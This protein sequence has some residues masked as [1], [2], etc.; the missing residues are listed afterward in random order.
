MKQ[1][2]QQQQQQQSHLVDENEII[3]VGGN[4]QSYSTRSIL[5]SVAAGYCAGVAGT[6]V[7]HPLDSLK[8]WLQT[9]HITNNT[10]NVTTLL[11]SASTTT[12]TTTTSS[13]QRAAVSYRGATRAMSTATTITVDAVA[14]NR[15]NLRVLQQQIRS[16]YAGVTGPL[17]TVGVVQSVNFAI[18]D[19]CRRILYAYDQQQ[20]QHA[21][22]YNHMDYLHNDSL[23]NVA[24]SGMAGG[25]VLSLFTNPLH[26]IKTRQQTTKGLQFRQ[27]CQ[28]LV[29]NCR[30][31]SLR[32]LY[33]GY[34]PH[35]V[36]EVLGRGTYLVA[37]EAFKRKLTLW[38]H[39]DCQQTP[40]STALYDRMISAAAAG[41]VCW[42]LIFPFDFF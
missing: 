15:W 5:N 9:A 34:G 22:P 36:T 17:L 30:N 37:Y 25:A 14:V 35:C 20:Q 7:G 33:V 21:M 8:V 2:Q 29:A 24:I 28:Q 39:S 19:S 40:T 38:R 32:S 3:S 10:N 42:A 4:H 27:A 23:I 12:T 18:Y 31:H 6:I 1:Q 41:M 13:Q 11:S 16:L 26:L